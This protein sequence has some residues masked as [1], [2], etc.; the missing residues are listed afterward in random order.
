MNRRSNLRTIEGNT[1]LSLM[2]SIFIGDC[3]TDLGTQDVVLWVS[4][5]GYWLTL[6]LIL[7]LALEYKNGKVLR[8][9]NCKSWTCFSYRLAP[10]SIPLSSAAF[11]LQVY[12]S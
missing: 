11:D 8:A 2:G 4:L 6:F 9:G 7:N 10:G 12:A 5:V 1:K 3:I